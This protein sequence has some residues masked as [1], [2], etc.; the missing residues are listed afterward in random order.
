MAACKIGE[1]AKSKAGHDKDEI[2]VIINIEEEYLYLAD[3][4]LR[5]LEKLKKKKQKHVQPI[6]IVDNELQMKI[7][8]NV[9]LR[10]EDIKKAIKCYKTKME[11]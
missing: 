7:D 8:S 6:N 10:N 1:F 9:T 3:G 4:K 2:F 5:T 11:K